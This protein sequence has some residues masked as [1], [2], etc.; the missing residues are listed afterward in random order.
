MIPQSAMAFCG[1]ALLLPTGQR[2]TARVCVTMRKGKRKPGPK[3][4]Q[5]S[6]ESEERIEGLASKYGIRAPRPGDDLDRKFNST[7]SSDPENQPPPSAYQRLAGAFGVE[8][9][10][11]AER[12]LVVALGTMLIAFLA[13]GLAISSE[14]FFKA[15]GKEIPD[16]VEAVLL[17]LEQAFTPTL[18]IFLALSSVFGLYKQSQLSSGASSYSA[19]SKDEETN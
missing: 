11:A 7:S 14:A 19:L 6:K 1:P 18:L 3:K 16:N 12:V 13:S 8:A 10:N 5:L 9:L 17:S 4:S 15:S 2:R